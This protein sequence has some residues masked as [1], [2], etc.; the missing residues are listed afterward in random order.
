VKSNVLDYYR[1][2]FGKV[3]MSDLFFKPSFIV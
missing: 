3:Q 1:S 2:V